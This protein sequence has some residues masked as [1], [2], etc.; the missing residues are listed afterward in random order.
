MRILGGVSTSTSFLDFPDKTKCDAAAA[1]IR[2]GVRREDLQPARRLRKLRLPRKP[3]GV[4]R[5]DRLRVVLDE[6]LASRRVLRLVAQRAAHGLL[7]ARADRAGRRAISTFR[8]CTSTPL[9]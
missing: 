4:L 7:R 6:M 2:Q 3:C 5:A 9:R 8:T 1:G